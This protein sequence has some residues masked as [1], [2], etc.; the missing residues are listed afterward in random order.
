[1][2]SVCVGV[3]GYS[4][5]YPLHPR[6]YAETFDIA[7]RFCG[8]PYKNILQTSSFILLLFLYRCCASTC[9]AK[10]IMSD[11]LRR[12]LDLRGTHNCTP[13]SQEKVE[14]MFLRLQMKAIT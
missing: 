4:G 14:R 1:M 7:D 3:A 8:I 10:V 6:A 12:V 2:F 5:N 13:M 9:N 11:D